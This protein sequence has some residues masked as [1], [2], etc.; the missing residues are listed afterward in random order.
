MIHLHPLKNYVPA[1][2]WNFLIELLSRWKYMKSL[3][4]YCQFIWLEI[5]FSLGL[6]FFQ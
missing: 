5:M 2:L 1:I 6:K 4:L 3:Y